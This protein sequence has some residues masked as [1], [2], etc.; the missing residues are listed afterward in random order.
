MICH[1]TPTPRNPLLLCHSPD[2]LCINYGDKTGYGPNDLS[3]I[4][5]LFN[6]AISSSDYIVSN[7]TMINEQWVGMGVKVSGRDL[8]QGTI[9]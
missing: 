2:Y 9:P 7:G 8:F 4:C 5:G 6:D 3:L 1:S